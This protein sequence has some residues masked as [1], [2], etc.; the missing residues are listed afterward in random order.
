MA[1]LH[2]SQ[3]IHRVGDPSPLD[4]PTRNLCPSL[5]MQALPKHGQPGPIFGH[6]TNFFQGRMSTG[7]KH[8]FP[9]MEHL[10]GC[11]RDEKVSE[12][13]RIKRPAKKTD[14]QS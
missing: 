4:F 7:Q 9:E 12:M 6:R 2:G 14:P 1:F 8:H 3:G 13:K 10:A 5:P 11:P